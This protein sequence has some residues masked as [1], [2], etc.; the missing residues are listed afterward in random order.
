MLQVVIGKLIIIYTLRLLH[1]NEA[2]MLFSWKQTLIQ[3]KTHLML[4]RKINNKND[5]TAVR[6]K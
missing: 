5:I 3:N 1:G 6:N 4:R 2:R